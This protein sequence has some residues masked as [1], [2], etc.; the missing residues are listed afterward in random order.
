MNEI[1]ESRDYYN[2]DC[3]DKTEM[4]QIYKYFDDNKDKVN[5]T[6]FNG[7]EWYTFCPVGLSDE[8]TINYYIISFISLILAFGTQC[9]T[10]KT[11]RT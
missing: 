6:D 8:W 4:N 5:E 9:I 2:F 7:L 1:V 3:L 10:F 11:K